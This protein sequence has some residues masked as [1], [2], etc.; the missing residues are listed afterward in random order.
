MIDN[1]VEYSLLGTIGV[2][3]V[4]MHMVYECEVQNKWVK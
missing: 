1:E 3:K 4:D 2:P